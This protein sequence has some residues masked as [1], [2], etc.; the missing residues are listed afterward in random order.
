MKSQF[1]GAWLHHDPEGSQILLGR[2]VLA[3]ATA[4]GNPWLPHL[5]YAFRDGKYLHL[6]MDYE[7]GGDLYI[8][9]SKVGH[10]LDSKMVQFYAAEAVEAI[11]S[12]HQMG[13]I[14]C[15]LKPENFAIERSGHLKLIDFG[16]AI[17]LHADGKC[18][19]PSMVGTKE[20]LNIELL[21]QR[22]RHN[23]EPLLVGPEFDY[24]CIVI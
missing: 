8:F 5:H 19:C 23:Q 24:W 20:H 14:H 3:Q 9:L 1:K 12:L 15:D 11:H 16:S 7:P 4:I 17:R 22:G 6:V 2:T 13:Y 21:R 18:I 10:L